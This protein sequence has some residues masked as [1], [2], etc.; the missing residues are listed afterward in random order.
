LRDPIPQ[1]PDRLAKTRLRRAGF[2]ETAQMPLSDAAH[3]DYENAEGGLGGKGA[4][5]ILGSHSQRS[6][7][8][9]IV[10]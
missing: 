8:N 5:G 4:V 2:L 7:N 1:L 9:Q 10:T 6:R 3:P